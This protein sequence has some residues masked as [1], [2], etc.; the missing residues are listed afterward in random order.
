VTGEVLPA[1]RNTGSY[2]QPAPALLLDD[3]T[4]LRNLL[5]GYTD[6]VLAPA[7]DNERLIGETGA[8]G[9]K[10]PEISNPCLNRGARSGWRSCMRRGPA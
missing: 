8:L 5:L 9:A 4:T 7:A 1:T 6:K 2:G 3:P 10:S